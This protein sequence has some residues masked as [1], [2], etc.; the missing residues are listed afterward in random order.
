MSS[1]LSRLVIVHD[2]NSL[3]AIVSPLKNNA[4][5]II[6]SYAVVTRQISAQNLKSIPRWYPQITQLKSGIQLVQLSNRDRP[7][8]SGQLSSG[9]GIATVKDIPCCIISK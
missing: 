5:L 7:K 8:V 2:F 3:G 9:F 6:D 1:F 4:K